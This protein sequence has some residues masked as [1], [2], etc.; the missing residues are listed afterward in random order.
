MVEVAAPAKIN[1]GL[2]VGPLRSDG[3]HEIFSPMLPVTLADLVTARPAPAGAGLAVE[4]AVAP[5]E[6]NLAARAVR[7]L[8]RRLERTFDVRLSIVK[9]VPAAAGLGGGSSDAAAALTA[10]ERLFALDLP[11]RLRYEVAGAVGSDVPFFLWPGPQ[12]AMGRGTVLKE[13]VLPEPLHVVDRPARPGP[14]DRRRLP[15]VR[16]ATGAPSARRLAERRAFVERT[17]TLIARLARRAARATWPPWSSNELEAPVV[18]RHPGSASSP[19]RCATAG[20]FAAAMSGS[21]SSVFGLFAQRG[22]R[23]ARARRAGPHARRLRD[24]PAARRR[25]GDR[26]RR[27]AL[28]RDRP[29]DRLRWGRR[30]STPRRWGVAKWQGNGFWS[31]DRRFES[32]RPSQHRGRRRAG[33]P[34]VPWDDRLSA[35]SRPSSRASRPLAVIVMAAGLGTRMKSELPKVL[36]HVC[37]RPLLLYVLDAARGLAPAR[38]VVVTGPGDDDPIAAV[39]PA[40]GERAV[41]H[42]RRGSGDAVRAGMARSTASTATCMVLERRRAAGRA[43]SCSPGLRRHHV[44]CRR[45]GDHHHGR[46]ATTRRTTGGSCATPQ[47][48]STRIVEARDASPDEL[49]HARVNVGFYVFDA[50]ALRRACP[51]CAPTTRRASS[52]SPTS[53]IASSP[54]ATGVAAFVTA[55]VEASIGVNSRVELAQVNAVMRRRTPRAPHARRR[56][57][58]RPVVDLRRLGRRRSAATPSFCRRPC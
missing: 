58:R 19:A 35:D 28:G 56:D 15:L 43:A 29:G 18:A 12:L 34:C 50:A 37:G 11:V 23:A 49:A 16:R 39:L 4:C 22:E 47:A 13:I 1:L 24:R 21:G 38:L 57:G 32:S 33:R 53:S 46:A 40:G 20:A 8:E 7:E 3:F 25:A 6:D 42:E 26:L 17:Q 51:A 30:L 52:T 27:R 54:T 48:A 2:L 14:V 44:D 10:L 45:P 5:G 41:Q 31:R 9:R 55:D 36:H